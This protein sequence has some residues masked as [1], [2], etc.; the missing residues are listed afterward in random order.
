MRASSDAGAT[1]EEVRAYAERVRALVEA[2]LERLVPAERDDPTSVH[3]A[4]RWSLFAP[5]KRFRPFLLFA[6]GETFDARPE[7][8][9]RAACAYEMIHTYS[10]IHDDLPAMDDD[11]LRR[12]RPTCHVRF[13]EATAILAGDALQ[14]IAF[15]T[16]AEDEML[17][18][19][20]RVR[21]VRFRH[22]AKLFTLERDGDGAPL[23]VAQQHLDAPLGL[24]QTLLTF[25]RQ[26][27]ALLEQLKTA[28]ERQVAALQFAHDSLQRRELR[29]EVRRRCFRRA[30]LCLFS[31]GH[32]Q[33]LRADDDFRRVRPSLSC[34]AVI[35][36]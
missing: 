20:L 1:L 23:S 4:I 31:F 34:Q 21:L 13:G 25:A 24:V 8:L 18:A 32:L 14:A 30:G 27:D 36:Y 28:F 26:L 11:E 19:P 29:L 33:S 9:V 17:D 10:L 16:I 22:A 5:A 12:G 2:E 15:Q 3:A 6:T 35:I 7:R